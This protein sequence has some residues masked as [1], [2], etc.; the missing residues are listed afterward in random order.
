MNALAADA[1]ASALDNRFIYPRKV[2][3]GVDLG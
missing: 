2:A 3:V 1:Q